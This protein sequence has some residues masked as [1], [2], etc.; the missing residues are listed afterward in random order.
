[1]TSRDIDMANQRNVQ[2]YSSCLLSVDLMFD[3]WSM[4]QSFTSKLGQKSHKIDKARLKDAFVTAI[5]GLHEV[6]QLVKQLPTS[7][8]PPGLHA[9]IAG[10]LY[11]L[12][13]IQVGYLRSKILPTSTTILANSSKRKW[14]RTIGDTYRKV[15]IDPWKIATWENALTINRRPNGWAVWVSPSYKSLTELI[16]KSP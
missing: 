16:W 7:V 3:S 2:L 14:H 9:G 15:I 5:N 8:G 12:D 10:L 11:V 13:A 6:L 4:L 1:M